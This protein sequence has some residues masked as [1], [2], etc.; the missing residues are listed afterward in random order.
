MQNVSCL[1]CNS[2]QQNL[3][4]RARPH[5]AK[6]I[7]EFSIVRCTSCQFVFLNPQPSEYE[8]AEMYRTAAAGSTTLNNE[9]V[10]VD[11][12]IRQLWRHL[13]YRSPAV[14]LIK[15][16]PVLDVGCG[17]GALMEQMREA[18]IDVEGIEPGEQ[19]CSQAR[20]KGLNVS[21]TTISRAA[22]KPSYYRYVVLSHVLEHLSDPISLLRKLRD[23]LAPD[24]HLIVLVPNVKSPMSRLFGP[25]WHG[26]DPPYHLYHFDCDTLCQVIE[27]AGLKVTFSCQRGSPD[28]LR[29]SLSLFLGRE[30][31]YLLLRIATWPLF[32]LLGRVGFGSELIVMAAKDDLKNG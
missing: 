26:W 32:A 21:C 12:R 20:A 5:H 7:E 16:G 6:E 24:G 19:S 11:G 27:A 29:R 30:H 23:G 1:L 17:D 15:N 14:K 25:Y 22:I 2:T 28:D 31:R 4:V 8:L 13:N 10:A 9:L 18:G 3:V